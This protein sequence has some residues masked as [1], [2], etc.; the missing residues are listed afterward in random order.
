MLWRVNINDEVEGIKR[1]C[2]VSADAMFV[3]KDTGAL[4]LFSYERGK[5][6]YGLKKVEKAVFNKGQW[7]SVYQ[8]GVSYSKD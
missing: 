4:H 1:I 7:E 2:L 8:Q 3:D 5:S 6:W